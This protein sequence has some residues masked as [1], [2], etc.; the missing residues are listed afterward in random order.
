VRGRQTFPVLV[1]AMT[2][3]FKGQAPDIAWISQA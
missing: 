2:C 3:Y 1:S